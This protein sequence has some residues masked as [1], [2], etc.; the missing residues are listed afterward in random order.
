MT[1]TRS[2][3]TPPLL[4]DGPVR[5]LRRWANALTSA[6]PRARRARHRTSLAHPPA[7]PPTVWELGRSELTAA[8]QHSR[9]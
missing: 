1:M 4:H 8:L 9:W 6:T 5:A 3:T 2:A 7:P